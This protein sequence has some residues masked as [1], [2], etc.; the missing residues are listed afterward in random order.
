MITHRLTGSSQ[1]RDVDM[2][3]RIGGTNMSSIGLPSDPSNC[4]PARAVLINTHARRFSV[5]GRGWPSGTPS[6]T[7]R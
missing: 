5:A 4:F 1:N 7:G 2:D 6:P 3:S